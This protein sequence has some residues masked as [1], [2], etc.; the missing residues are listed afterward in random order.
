MATGVITP[1]AYLTGPGILYTAPLLT[2]LPASTVTA[3]VFG[4]T[5]TTWTAVGSTADG[6]QFN[7]ALSTDD[8]EAAESYYPVRTITTKRE[9]KMAVALQEFTASNLKKALNTTTASTSG[10]GATLL[11]EIVPP[12]VGAEVRSMWGWQSEDDTVR[13]IAYQA[14]QVGDIGT[15]FTKGANNAELTFELKLEVATAGVYR[16]QLAGAVRGA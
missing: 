10:S 6:W 2:A 11:T 16:I 8:V 15:R 3:S 13:F 1:A 14:L 12:T 4:T 5:W 7:D 9:A